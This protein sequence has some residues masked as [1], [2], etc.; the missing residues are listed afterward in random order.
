MG[1][2][3][4]SAWEVR[5]A[6]RVA[7]APVGAEAAVEQGVWGAWSVVV[8]GPASEKSEG[9]PPALFSVIAEEVE[10]SRAKKVQ[11]F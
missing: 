9:Q 7:T 10:G 2:V 6:G 5:A 3:R 4:S 8:E 11:A 1:R